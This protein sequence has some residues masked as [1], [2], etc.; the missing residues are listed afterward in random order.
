MGLENHTFIELILFVLFLNLILIQK[1]KLHN[2]LFLFL[3]VLEGGC[4]VPEMNIHNFLSTLYITAISRKLDMLRRFI[5]ENNPKMPPKMI[6]FIRS[7]GLVLCGNEHENVMTISIL[8][9]YQ[10]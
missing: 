1:L 2:L 4:K 6:N 8:Y 9:K 7:L 3:S 10:L 5:P